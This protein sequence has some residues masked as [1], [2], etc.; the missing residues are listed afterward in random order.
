M[1]D[2]ERDNALR[3]LAILVKRLGGRVEISDVELAEAV[4]LELLMDQDVSK[5][6]TF[7]YRIRKRP[8]TIDVSL[9]A[10]SVVGRMLMDGEQ[11]ERVSFAGSDG[12]PLPEP[13]TTRAEDPWTC[14]SGHIHRSYGEAVNCDRARGF[15]EIT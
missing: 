15:E 8:V 6:W 13:Q 1:F 5:P 12:G 9:A 14:L 2:P 7:I 4:D 3:L 11:I 10:P